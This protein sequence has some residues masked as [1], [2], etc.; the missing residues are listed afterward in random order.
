MHIKRDGGYY[1]VEV[2]EEWQPSAVGKGREKEREKKMGGQQERIEL[3]YT[4]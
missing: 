3:E 1:R 4:S 2:D